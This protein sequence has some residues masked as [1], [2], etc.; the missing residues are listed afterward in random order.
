MNENIFSSRHTQINARNSFLLTFT[1]VTGRVT[2]MLILTFVPKLYTQCQ[3]WAIT[4]G[5]ELDL[6]IMKT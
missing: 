3:F 5:L 6:N 2:K 1:L 4:Q